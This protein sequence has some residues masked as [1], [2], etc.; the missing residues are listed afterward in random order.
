MIVGNLCIIRGRTAQ[1]VGVILVGPLESRCDLS[2]TTQRVGILSLGGGNSALE[3][4]MKILVSMS[5]RS[6]M[7]LSNILDQ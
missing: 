6:S 5:L 2:R 7:T 4:G 1:N 3:T